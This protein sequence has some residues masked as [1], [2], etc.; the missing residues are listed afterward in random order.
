M[1]VDRA[2]HGGKLGRRQE[3]QVQP[4]TRTS[5]CSSRHSSELGRIDD[6]QRWIGGVGRRLSQSGWLCGCT[7]GIGCAGVDTSRCHDVA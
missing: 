7:L 5:R 3:P 6:A 1:A 4:A 2:V